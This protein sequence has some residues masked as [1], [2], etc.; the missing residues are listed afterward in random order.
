V[1]TCEWFSLYQL[2]LFAKIPRCQ[3]WSYFN[4]ILRRTWYLGG[5][6][7]INSLLFTIATIPNNADLIDQKR[8]T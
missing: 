1:E 3:W 2:A 8:G 6:I 5:I 4:L 7:V